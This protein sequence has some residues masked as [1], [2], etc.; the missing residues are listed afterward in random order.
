VLDRSGDGVEDDVDVRAGLGR[1]LVRRQ[2]AAGLGRRPALAYQLLLR[3]GDG[4]ADPLPQR[5]VAGGLGEQRQQR[6]LAL[7]LRQ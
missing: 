5:R 2:F 4:L 7:R 3:V 1:V 6:G